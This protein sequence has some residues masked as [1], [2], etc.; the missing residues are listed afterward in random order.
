[1]LSLPQHNSRKRSYETYQKKTMKRHKPHTHTHTHTH[2]LSLS[3]SLS[4]SQYAHFDQF[5]RVRIVARVS[6]VHSID[7]GTV[8]HTLR[9]AVLSAQRRNCCCA[10][11]DRNGLTVSGMLPKAPRS[12]VQA[13]IHQQ[14]QLVCLPTLIVHLAVTLDMQRTPASLHPHCFHKQ[15]W[16]FRPCIDRGLGQSFDKHS[17]V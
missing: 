8:D 16:W 17:C 12:L 3:L 15:T 13:A 7:V 4:L 2:T 5:A 1:M 6:S 11:S 10:L 9:T 14:R